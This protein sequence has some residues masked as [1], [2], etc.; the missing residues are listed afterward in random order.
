MPSPSVKV[1]NRRGFALS[2]VVE[3]EER[4]RHSVSYLETFTPLDQT[5]DAPVPAGGTP[6]EL[7]VGDEVCDQSV[8]ASTTWSSVILYAST[9]EMSALVNSFRPSTETNEMTASTTI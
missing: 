2:I 9:F 6:T 4:C 3:R 1:L 7:A 5:I 8:G